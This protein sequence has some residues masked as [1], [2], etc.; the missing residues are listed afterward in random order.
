MSKIAFVF[1]GQGAQYVGMG[2]DLAENYPVAAGVY[3]EA[4][5]VLGFDVGRLCFE[6]PEEELKKTEYTQP[7]ILTT[8]IACLRVLHQHGI[9]P[10]M[11]AGLS[12]GEYSALVAA[13]VL[14]FTDAVRL[15][16]N[17][18]RYMQEAVPV[19]EGGMAAIIGLDH[20]KVQ[21]ACREGA[22]RGIVEPANFNC[23]GQVVIS[24]H[25]EA[26][27][28]SIE[29]ARSLGA[30]KVVP[31]KVSAPFHCQ[32]M[33]PA[34]ER[35]EHDLA[36][37]EM[38]EPVIPVFANVSGRP[39]QGVADIERSLVQQVSRPVLWETTIR[40]ML[41]QGAQLFLEVGPGT[42]LKGFIKKIDRKA[43]VL[44]AGDLPSIDR[45]LDSWQGACYNVA[46]R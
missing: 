43:R 39:V 32:L 31:L 12:L 15:V 5:R 20:R 33:R 8:S 34:G 2:K 6:G 17:R 35:L 19:G 21:E 41:K 1:P 16:R 45:I 46:D 36:E 14:E 44:S 25:Q 38:S 26:V 13:G 3:E 24:G 23:P 40:R 29:V 42:T 22:A 28:M 7:A 30:K 27:E 11:V 18:G 4:S 37:V 9:K 10:D